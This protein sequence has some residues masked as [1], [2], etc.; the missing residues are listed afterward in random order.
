MLHRIVVNP[1]PFGSGFF[2]F[3]FRIRHYLFRI[4]IRLKLKFSYRYAT[5][6]LFFILGRF[7]FTEKF[8]GWFLNF[9][10]SISLKYS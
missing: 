8:G 5:K 6:I 1:D 7:N 10:L 4:R 2:W 9:F 3:W